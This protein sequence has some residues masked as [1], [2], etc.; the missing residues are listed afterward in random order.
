MGFY[1]LVVSTGVDS[2][3]LSILHKIFWQEEL[4]RDRKG[5]VTA[6]EQP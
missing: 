3:L 1:V 6:G 4:F 2:D 5:D